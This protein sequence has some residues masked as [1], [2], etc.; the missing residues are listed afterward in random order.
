VT[1]DERQILA[2]Y[3]ELAERLGLPSAVAHVGDVRAALALAE[4]LVTEDPA[5]EPA[6]VFY[7]FSRYPRAFP[8]LARAMTTLLALTC[9]RA[10]GIVLGSNDSD[11]LEAMVFGVASQRVGFEQVLAYFRSRIAQA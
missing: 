2:A 11:A 7:A 9:A 6:A 10:H 4:P 5:S 3:A 8:R 1:L